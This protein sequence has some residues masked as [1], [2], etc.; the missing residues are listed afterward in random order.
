MIA[1]FRPGLTGIV[2]FSIFELRISLL[3]L[4]KPILSYC[5]WSFHVS[6]WIFNCNLLSLRTAPVPNNVITLI[7]PNPRISN[8][9]LI[10]V[11]SQLPI[12]NPFSISL[13]STLSSATKRWPRLISSNAISLLP[14]P[15]SPVNRT[16]IP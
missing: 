15:L 13:I 6:K 14:I 4:P 12:K 2:F 7:I 3:S 5:F 11:D 16:P 8:K 10:K 9:C 1:T